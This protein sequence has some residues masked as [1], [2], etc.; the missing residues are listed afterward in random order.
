M[1]YTSVESF[2]GKFR[3]E[4]DVEVNYNSP[5]EI[6]ELNAIKTHC[7]FNAQNE[8]PL[9]EK[10]HKGGK[11]ESTS[12]VYRIKDFSASNDQCFKIDYMATDDIQFTVSFRAFNDDTEDLIWKFNG[13]NADSLSTVNMCL[14]QFIAVSS[15]RFFIKFSFERVGIVKEITSNFWIHISQP[16]SPT[17]DANR[18][19]YVKGKSFLSAMQPDPLRQ[20]VGVGLEG[21][22]ASP[23]NLV[24]YDKVASQ[25]VIQGKLHVCLYFETKH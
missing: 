22:W 19:V 23:N 10:C 4:N 6:F 7:A 9:N 12:I 21:E 18:Q 16:K 5:E 8:E 24:T 3:N 11:N 1:E 2:E 25:I 14:S 17:L 15:N 20:P 13:R